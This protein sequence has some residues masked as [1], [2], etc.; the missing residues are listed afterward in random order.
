[1][2]MLLFKTTLIYKQ[3]TTFKKCWKELVPLVLS[4]RR[5]PAT[6]QLFVEGFYRYDKS[7]KKANKKEAG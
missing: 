6:F 4:I 2:A 7:M 5:R 3:V 1:M